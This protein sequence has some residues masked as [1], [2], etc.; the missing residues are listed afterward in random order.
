ML[1]CAGFVK[2]KELQTLEA[3]TR[4]KQKT[5]TLNNE[6]NYIP[7]SFIHTRGE[8]VV[9]PRNNQRII[10]RWWKTHGGLIL[11]RLK[12]ATSVN[13]M[14]FKGILHFQLVV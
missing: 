13:A 9:L 5:E 14:L 2:K 8:K 10:S 6:K 7:I 3:R 1:P 4:F 12:F 11:S